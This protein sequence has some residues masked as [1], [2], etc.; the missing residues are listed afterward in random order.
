MKKILLVLTCVSLV[1]LQG[2]YHGSVP[3]RFGHSVVRLGAQDTFTAGT[4][5][6][7]SFRRNY[8]NGD[9]KTPQVS[10]LHF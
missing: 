1:Y 4:T 3:R 2:E 7:W 10:N 5:S 9:K 6:L 8:R